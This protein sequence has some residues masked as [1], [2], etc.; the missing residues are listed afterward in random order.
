MP[1]HS[2]LSAAPSQ[3]T[4]VHFGELPPFNHTGYRVLSLCAWDNWHFRLLHDSCT[5][6]IMCGYTSSISIPFL[7][8]ETQI[9]ADL[10]SLKYE[11]ILKQMSSAYQGLKILFVLQEEGF[12]RLH[13]L[14]GGEGNLLRIKAW[15][16]P[17]W[18]E[19]F[20]HLISQSN[21]SYSRSLP[22]SLLSG[23]KVLLLYSKAYTKH[24]LCICSSKD[25]DI[26]P[27]SQ[28]ELIWILW[29]GT[30]H[31]HLKLET[32]KCPV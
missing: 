23:L 31:S 7:V 3:S 15:T 27:Y 30:I 21:M 18:S 29:I 24:K 26:C 22:K 14:N 25:I 32:L 17:P 16:Y 11:C 13:E 6:S 2:T 19:V 20:S 5:H 1:L 12:Y 9:M 8:V 4:L 28:Y 10:V